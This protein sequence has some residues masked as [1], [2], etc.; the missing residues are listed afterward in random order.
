MS[1]AQNCRLLFLGDSITESLRGTSYGMP[2]TRSIGIPEVLQR[3][4]GELSPLALA[5]S[6]DQTQHLLWRIEN[7]EF[8]RRL[9]PEVWCMVALL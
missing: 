9:Q 6:G 3:E 5:I 8:P 2:S 7:G 1:S 4:F